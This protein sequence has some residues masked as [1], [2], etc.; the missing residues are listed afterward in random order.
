M[1]LSPNC[2]TDEAREYI[3]SFDG[4]PSLPYPL[5]DEQLREIEGLPIVADVEDLPGFEHL[6]NWQREANF[7]VLA[8]WITEFD[9]RNL[10][11]GA[12]HSSMPCEDIS[13]AFLT[14]SRDNAETL[15]HSCGTA[16]CMA[17][18]AQTM[19]GVPAFSVETC[20]YAEAALPAGMIQNFWEPNEEAMKLMR[21]FVASCE[22]GALSTT[23]LT[24]PL[25]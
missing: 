1:T 5:S 24:A 7:L 8:V 23:Q 15:Y 6:E 11:M 10:D 22:A 19:G 21:A 18:F 4:L 25:P 9:A 2:T 16:H 20:H 17:G 3:R 13:G 14:H 12:W